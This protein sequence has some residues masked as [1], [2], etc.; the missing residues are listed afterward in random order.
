MKKNIKLLFIIFSIMFLFSGTKIFA[1]NDDLFPKDPRSFSPPED[2]KPNSFSNNTVNNEIKDV[3]EIKV[4][5]VNEKEDLK[6]KNTK[7]AKTQNKDLIA[8]IVFVLIIFI[9]LFFAVMFFL[10]FRNI[11]ET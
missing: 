3:K 4:A 10:I 7:E 2:I 11:R 6:P 9:V 1:L 5:P 8:I